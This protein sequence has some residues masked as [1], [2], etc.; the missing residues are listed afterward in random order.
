MTH[1]DDA[2]SEPTV[3]RLSLSPPTIVAIALGGAI[4]T[5]ARFLLDTALAVPAGHFPTTTLL[6]NLTGSLAIGLLIPLTDKLAPRVPLARPFLIVGILGGWT[7]YS[8]FTVDAV[9][10]MKDGHA[11]S[12]VLYLAATVFGGLASVVLGNAVGRRMRPR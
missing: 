1:T 8:T 4:G 2:L 10:L 12:S 3:P 9:T 11:A 5:V 6:I 7:T